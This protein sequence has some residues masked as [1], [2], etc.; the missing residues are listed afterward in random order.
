MNRKQIERALENKLDRWCASIDNPALV[1]AIRKDIIITGGC[2]VSFLTNEPVND[3]D[4]Y[5][6]TYDTAIA[7]AGYYALKFQ[8]IPTR[9]FCERLN[10]KFRIEIKEDKDANGEITKKGFE[11]NILPEGDPIASNIFSKEF[12]DWVENVTRERDEDVINA[13]FRPIYVSPQAVSLSSDAPDKKGGI[14]IVTPFF[15]EP[16]EI[17]SNYDFVHCTNYWTPDGGLVLREQ[18]MEAILARRL[19][20]VG[21]RYP[22]C[23]LFRIRKFVRRGWNI[24]AGQILKAALQVS[25]LDW[26]DKDTVRQ[27]CIGVDTIHFEEMLEELDGIEGS[28]KAAIPELVDKIWK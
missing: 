8:E 4:V 19:V 21:S 1:T 2:I 13:P 9:R 11:I 12:I 17:H 22:L 16:D 14:Q 3:Y 5:F 20:Y 27:Q 7:V 23:S 6:R 26:D 24:D 25:E 15:G 10:K 28:I 18:A